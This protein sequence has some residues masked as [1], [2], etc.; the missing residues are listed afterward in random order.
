M[1]ILI[2]APSSVHPFYDG[3][4]LRV[5][6]IVKQL[7]KR[8]SLDLIQ[9]RWPWESHREPLGGSDQDATW[10]SRNFQ[11]VVD[12]WHKQGEKLRFGMIWESPDL[13]LK[14]D[15]VLNRTTYDVIWAPGEAFPL[16]SHLRG[17]SFPVLTGPTDSMHLQYRRRLVAARNPI[18]KVKTAVKWGLFIQYQLRILN[19]MRHLLV[20]ADK[21][22]RSMKRLSPR[23]NFHVVANGVDVDYLSP[24]ENNQRIPA[25][26]VFLGTLGKDSPNEHSVFWFLRTVWPIIHKTNPDIIFDIIGPGQS[27]SLA[28]TVSFCRNVRLLGYL[29][30]IRPPLWSAGVFVLPMQSGAGIKNKLLEAWAAGCAVLSTPL[31]IEGVSLAMTDENIMVASTPLDFAMQIKNAVENPERI[32]RIAQAGE[33]TVHHH[34]RWERIAERLEQI[35][36]RIASEYHA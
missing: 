2:H 33:E 26:L 20:V 13:F 23:I 4:S 24:P 30:D 1:R 5:F 35:L 18:T 7:A 10:L 3:S 34:Y 36:I 32:T 16:Y 22:A 12:V 17:V 31:G 27:D 15:E 28:S 6:H 19:K 14:L 8:H 25:K 29:E 21:D 9:E 11:H